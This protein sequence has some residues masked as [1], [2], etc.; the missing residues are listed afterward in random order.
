MEAKA[1][2]LEWDGEAAQ[3]RHEYGVMPAGGK[4]VLGFRS[5][6]LQLWA[7]GGGGDCMIS[8]RESLNI[9]T[10]NTERY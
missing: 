9:R 2:L 1:G 10:C 4:G 5:R 7:I 6:A 3:Y 8:E